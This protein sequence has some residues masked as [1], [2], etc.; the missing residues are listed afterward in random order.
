[1]AEVNKLRATFFR[2]G[3]RDMIEI[4]II[5]DPNTVIRKVEPKDLSQFASEWTAYEAGKGDVDVGG[6][7]LTEVPGIL[8]ALAVAWKLKGVRNAEEL[9]AL[10]D[11]A[12]RSLGMNALSFRTAAQ[13]LL[14]AREL[15]ELKAERAE[16]AERKTRKAAV[17]PVEEIT[18]A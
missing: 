6:T 8:P 18:T 10:D 4:K 2:D 7:P 12:I 9:A 15:A 14:A 13:N 1:M 11:H 17:E 16:R 5:G 3:A